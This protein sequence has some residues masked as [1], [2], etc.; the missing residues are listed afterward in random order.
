MAV[1]VNGAQNALLSP[2]IKAATTGETGSHPSGTAQ[3][4]VAAVINAMTKMRLNDRQ[5]LNLLKTL[6]IVNSFPRQLTTYRFIQ[7]P[8]LENRLLT[9]VAKSKSFLSL[10]RN[11]FYNLDSIRLRFL[12]IS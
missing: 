12:T 10:F 3:A 4:S 8:R 6:R 5:P 9:V 7:V 2:L 1:M 11:S